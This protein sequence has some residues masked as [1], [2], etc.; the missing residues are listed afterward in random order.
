[1]KQKLE[2]A[3]DILSGIMNRYPSWPVGLCR[4]HRLLNQ[5]LENDLADWIDWQEDDRAVLA[6]D[7]D[8][9]LVGDL[10]DEPRPFPAA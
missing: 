3:R 10:P 7:L 6:T 1:M 4:V 5:V 9:E 8:N 2:E